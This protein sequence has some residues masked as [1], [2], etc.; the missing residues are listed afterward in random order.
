MKM[1]KIFITLLVFT[2]YCNSSFAKPI[3]YYAESSFDAK[4]AKMDKLIAQDKYTSKQIEL[5]V[6]IGK[7]GYT[8]CFQ[9]SNGSICKFTDQFCLIK[10]NN[11]LSLKCIKES[12]LDALLSTI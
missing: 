6:K 4:L 5:L 3:P 9:S 2:F 1:K 8:D 7:E 10:S 12:E 11:G